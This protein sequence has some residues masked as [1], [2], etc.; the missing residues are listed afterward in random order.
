MLARLTR[1]SSRSH[2]IPTVLQDGLVLEHNLPLLPAHGWVVGYTRASGWNI[3]TVSSAFLAALSTGRNMA[4]L[5]CRWFD[6]TLFTIFR[7]KRCYDGGLTNFIPLPPTQHGVRV[8]CFPSKQITTIYDIGISPDNYEDWPH[9]LQEMLSW[10]FEPA[11]DKLLLE[12]IGELPS[13]EVTAL[14]CRVAKLTQC[15]QAR[16]CMHAQ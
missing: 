4:V 6:N 5:N 7:G 3:G 2:V 10:A 16:R 12:F 9:T 15:V 8:C 14:S 11:E 1:V 13:F